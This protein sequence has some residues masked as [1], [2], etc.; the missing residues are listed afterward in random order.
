MILDFLQISSMKNI[1]ILIFF[2]YDVTSNLEDGISKK[3][4]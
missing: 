1:V 4:N 2:I 3:K